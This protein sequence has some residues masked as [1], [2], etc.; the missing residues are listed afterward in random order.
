MV[1]DNRS[2]LH[3]RVI[4]AAE[5]ALAENGYV[6]PVD[7]LTGVRWLPPSMLR[8]W[9]QGRVPCLEQVMN[10]KPSRILEALE[11]LR[12]WANQRGLQPSVAVYVA[13]TPERPRLRF[14][15]SGNADLEK[16][17]CTHF[18]S[19]ALSEKKRAA[20]IEKASH[21]PELVVV[22][23]LKHDWKCHRCGKTGDLLMMEEGGPACLSCVGLDDLEYL[24]R[25]D[26]NL[27][28]KAKAKSTRHAVVVRFSRARK[29]YE[30]QGLLVEAQALKEAQEDG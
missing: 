15:K 10:V 12:A 8:A 1:S 22:S 17:Y 18:I 3:E 24:P 28:R 30:R 5:E 9:R 27:T 13:R 6:A 26:A 19:P 25:G 29:R 4:K 23:P 20:L 16:D 7:V 11:M 2:K 21:P 14:G